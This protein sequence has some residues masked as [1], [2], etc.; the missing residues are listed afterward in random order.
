MKKKTKLALIALG[1]L[2]TLSAGA[3]LLLKKSEA[4]EYSMVY[5]V[6]GQ[7]YIGQLSFFPKMKIKS[8][9]LFEIVRD[10]K[11]ATKTNFQL[12]PLTEAIWAPKTIYLNPKNVVFYGPIG[13]SSK[14]AEALK[15]NGN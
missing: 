6:S 10:P 12:S 8:S 2:I 1:I 9:Y 13:D 3:L 11:D 4:K 15:K 7:A 14:I 5:L